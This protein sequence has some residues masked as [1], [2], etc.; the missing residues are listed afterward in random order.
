M[1]HMGIGIFRPLPHGMRVVLGIGLDG[2]GY[3]AIGISFPKNRIHRRPQHLGIP[4]FYL[5]FSLILWII[6]IIR[7]IES[8]PLEFGNGGLELGN[9]G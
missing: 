7:H 1:G 2:T 8:L 6:R 3:P 4:G 5:R 9:G